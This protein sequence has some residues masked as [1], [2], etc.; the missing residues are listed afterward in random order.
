[1]RPVRS[2]AAFAVLASLFAAGCSG[3]SSDGGSPSAATST[4]PA[5][6]SSTAPVPVARQGEYSYV[7]AGLDATVKF[8]SSGGGA[9]LTLKNSTGRT[10]EKPGLYV[11]QAATGKQINGKVVS[12][13]PVGDG[14]TSTF[15]V[16]FPPDVHPDTIGLLILLIGPDNYGAFVPPASG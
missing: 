7:N 3:G 13:A 12:A 6:S 5:T 4:A 14:R 10:L 9:T 2:I 11:E 1:M 16:T 8:G 15:R